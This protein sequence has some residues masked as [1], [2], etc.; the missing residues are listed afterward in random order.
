[1]HRR[2]A[3]CP[4]SD[5]FLTRRSRLLSQQL[6]VRETVRSKEGFPRQFRFFRRQPW[7][8]ELYRRKGSELQKVG[9]STLG[10]A[11]ALTSSVVL[12]GFHLACGDLRSQIEV[13]HVETGQRWVV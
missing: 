12:L 7:A 6:I 1:M 3:P 10:R 8:L 13:T 11:D 5:S 2:R 9:E 4:V